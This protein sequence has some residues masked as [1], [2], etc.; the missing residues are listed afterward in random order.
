MNLIITEIFAYIAVALFAGFILGFFIKSCKTNIKDSNLINEI[1]LDNLKNEYEKKIKLITE[2]KEGNKRLSELILNE[3]KEQ[4]SALESKRFFLEA[5]VSK[6]KKENLNLFNQLKDKN[7]KYILLQSKLKKSL[8]LTQ[9]L[10]DML[11][12][13][14]NKLK[15]SK[16]I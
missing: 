11:N 15:E 9:N 5:E 8:K 7:N 1:E 10:Q 16:K 6:L 12:D 13:C 2:E 3:L 4:I 14:K